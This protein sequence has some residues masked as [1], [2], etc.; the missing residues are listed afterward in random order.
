MTMFES[1]CFWKTP[2]HEVRGTNPKIREMAREAEVQISKGVLPLQIM[3]IQI[4]TLC[5]RINHRPHMLHRHPGFGIRK[6]RLEIRID[7]C[8]DILPAPQFCAVF[9]RD[10]RETSIKDT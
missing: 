5:T 2:G 3:F 9:K 10:V 1:L 7:F 4:D 6:F 8:D